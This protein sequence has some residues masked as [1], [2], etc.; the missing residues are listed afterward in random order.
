[1]IHY[2]FSCSHA[3][4]AIPEPHR[5][6]FQAARA[7]VESSAGWEPGVLNLGQAFAMH[8]RT[9]L[10][11]GEVSRLLIDL[12]H[13]GEERWSRHSLPLPEATRAKLVERHEKP[14]RSL[15]RQRI[16][17]TIP[18]GGI[19]LHLLLHTHPNNDGTIDL[20]TPQPGS[21][22]EKIAGHWRNLL[23]NDGFYV[24]VREQSGQSSLS[25]QL[26]AE[27]PAAGYQQLRLGVS[28]SFFLE[29][30]PHKW[31]FLKKRLVHTLQ[32]ASAE[33]EA[34]NAPAEPLSDPC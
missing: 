16:G 6:L 2:L 5:E 14:Y 19:L 32:K 25:R 26:A 4:C 27:H 1:M 33:Y 20:E 12:E 3:T 17:D 15:L 8:F 7:D 23:M 28:Q 22:A 34:L 9:P 21:A 18:R 29:G 10:V 11:H 31:D 13:E 24:R 30:K